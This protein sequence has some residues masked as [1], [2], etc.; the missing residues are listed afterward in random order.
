MLRDQTRRTMDMKVLEKLEVSD[1]EQES[2]GSY[3]TWFGTRH[4]DHPWTRLDNAHFLEMVGAASDD[5]EDRR[6]HP[7]CAGLLMFGEEF[8]ITREYPSFFLDYRDHADLSVRW[9]DRVQSQSADWSGNVFDFFVTVSRKLLRQ[10][11]VPFQLVN[12]VRVD[13]TPLHDAVREAMVNC[14]V[15]A[16]YYLPRGVVIE[17]YEDKFVL[18]NPG[19]IIVGKRQMM[20]GGDSEPRNA[21][22]MKMFNLIG[23]GER[24]GSGVPDI[25]SAWKW[26]G[27]DEPIIEESFGKD[28]PSK[29]IVTLPL[30]PKDRAPFQEGPEK[31]PEKGPG[32]ETTLEKS[33]DNKAKEIEKRRQSVLELL[34][35]D[36]SMSRKEIANKLAISEKQVRTAIEILKNE[37]VIYHDGPP[38]GGRWV[39]NEKI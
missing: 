12:T 31:G 5:C 37:K 7:T 19:T 28:G 8:C 15:N 3:R 18:K 27:Y 26:A 32:P 9:T 22:I 23:F 39:I 4:P 2:V 35:S 6:I 38:R 34:R 1:L 29:T 14:L 33:G 10:L 21:N 36:P 11:K 16:D 17:S 25:Y 30:V 24:A 13:D 20:K